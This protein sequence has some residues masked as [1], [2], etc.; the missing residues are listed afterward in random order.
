VNLL[1]PS[2]GYGLGLR[3]EFGNTFNATIAP[4]QLDL[5]SELVYVG[6]GGTTEPFGATEPPVSRRRC[7]DNRWS[8]ARSE[9]G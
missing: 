4:F 2:V 3:T 9:L 5:D 7:S 1:V 6:D 8:P